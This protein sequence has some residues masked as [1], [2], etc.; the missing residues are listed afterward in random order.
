MAFGQDALSRAD[1]IA[2]G[3]PD[4]YGPEW[5]DLLE[6]YVPGEELLKAILEPLEAEGFHA[7][8]V[9]VGEGD[10]AWLCQ[11]ERQS[12]GLDFCVW[13]EEGGQVEIELLDPIDIEEVDRFTQALHAAVG[14]QSATVEWH[15]PEFGEPNPRLPTPPRFIE[16]ARAATPAEGPPA[17]EPPAASPPTEK[18]PSEKKPWWRRLF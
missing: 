1:M 9:Q 3:D 8:D 16:L 17:E 5:L 14:Q 2:T 7:L 6:Y 13:G 18:K 15:E 4:D 12:F 10:W 11:S